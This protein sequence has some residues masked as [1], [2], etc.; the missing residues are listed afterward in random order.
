MGNDKEASWAESEGV[1]DVENL[2]S[3]SW[4]VFKEIKVRSGTMS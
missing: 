2:V 1:L 4:V 3:K